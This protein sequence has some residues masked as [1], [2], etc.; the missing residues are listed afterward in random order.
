MGVV[1]FGVLLFFGLLT[2][3]R[4]KTSR[5]G[6]T[7]SSPLLEEDSSEEVSS[8]DED[9][10]GEAGVSFPIAIPIKFG[11]LSIVVITYLIQIIVSFALGYPLYAS[12]SSL[13][14]GFT[15]VYYLLLFFLHFFFLFC[16]KNCESI[17]FND[18]NLI[19][20]IKLLVLVLAIQEWRKKLKTTMCLL[21][22]NVI[23]ILA[24]SVKL[25]T[26][27]RQKELDLVWDIIYFCQYG[28]IFLFLFALIFA[29]SSVQ[30]FENVFF[31]FYHELFFFRKKSLTFFFSFRQRKDC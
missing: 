2:V 30:T 19:T 29:P 25:R 9:E 17:L 3:T 26:V 22:F 15:W 14:G 5:I 24:G 10:D 23:F 4:F 12:V 31:F 1:P 11:L 8:D 18:T 28:A 13:I 21:I 27:V 20:I 16:K 7:E 6:P